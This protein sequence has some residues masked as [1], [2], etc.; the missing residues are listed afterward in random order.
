MQDMEIQ[1]YSQICFFAMS[2]G[3]AN[4]MV[5]DCIQSR[6]QSHMGM[7]IFLNFPLQ[8]QVENSGTLK[9]NIKKVDI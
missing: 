9:A 1:S 2:L 5:G 3:T 7:D 6:D 8:V 4:H